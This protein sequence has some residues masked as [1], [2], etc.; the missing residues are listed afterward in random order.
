MIEV[1]KVNEMA[2]V[3]VIAY[4]SLIFLKIGTTIAVHAEIHTVH[5]R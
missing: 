2:W 5:A 4:P 1:K 3:C